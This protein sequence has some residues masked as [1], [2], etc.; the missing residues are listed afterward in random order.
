MTDD[1]RPDEEALAGV[2]Q[3]ARADSASL[4]ERI[5]AVRIAWQNAASID[6]RNVVRV[7]WPDL[8]AALDALVEPAP[9]IAGPQLADPH[10]RVVTEL[11]EGGPPDA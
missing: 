3:R 4:L 7:A 9:E 1:A 6:D 8:A 5:D 11:D 10:G 2:V